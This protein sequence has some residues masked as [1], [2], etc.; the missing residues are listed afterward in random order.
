MEALV[1]DPGSIAAWVSAGLA[2]ALVLERAYVRA[3]D[4]TSAWRTRTDG[5]LDALKDS[6]GVLRADLTVIAA[7]VA[8]QGHEIERL[9]DREDTGP[10]RSRA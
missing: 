4:D 1:I 8:T 3:K 9:R 7:H 10:Q 5:K 2:A 6:V